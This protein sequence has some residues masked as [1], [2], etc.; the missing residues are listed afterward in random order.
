[1]PIKVQEHMNVKDKPKMYLVSILSENHIPWVFCMQILT[2]I[3][4]RSDEDALL[5]TEEIQAN[6]EGFC[7]IYM[8]EIAE[9]KAVLVEKL[10]EKENFSVSCLIEET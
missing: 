6:G 2:E 1:M 7:G 10:A 8:F 5:I 9:T 4:H 3:F